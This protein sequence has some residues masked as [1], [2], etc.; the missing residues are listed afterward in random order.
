MKKIFFFLLIFNFSFA[1]L[2]VK[3]LDGTPINNGDIIAFSSVLESVAKMKF[4]IYNTSST[5]INV[6]VRCN[7]LTNTDGSA[8]QLCLTDC[9]FGV[10]IG[11]MYPP[12]APLLIPANSNIGGDGQYFWNSDTGSGTFPLD[13]SFRFLMVDANG[14]QIGSPI[15]FTYRYNPNLD[16]KDY[17]KLEQIGIKLNST[18]VSD[19]LII[20]ATQ[21]SKLSF[22]DLS[23]KKIIQK[24]INVGTNNINLEN[25]SKGM[26]IATF[27]T[28]NGNVASIK[29]MIK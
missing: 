4:K 18:F 11:Q 20:D 12:G 19:E 28:E 21:V 7:N 10:S 2:E 27:T 14:A 23:A 15:N 3:K 1:Q 6:K 25:I 17:E 16:V 5:P 26:Y 8:M 13:Y 9:Y 22:F 24:N 29:I